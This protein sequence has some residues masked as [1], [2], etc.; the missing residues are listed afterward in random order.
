MLLDVPTPQI[1]M[2]SYIKLHGLAKVAV[3]GGVAVGVLQRGAPE[4][5]RQNYLSVRVLSG[6]RGWNNL[7]PLWAWRSLDL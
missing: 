4:P 2:V 6:I 3:G 1:C 7:G 5:F